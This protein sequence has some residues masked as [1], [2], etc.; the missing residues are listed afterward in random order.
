MKKQILS[1]Q[2]RRMQKLAGIIN[3]SE[4]KQDLEET[5]VELDD[6]EQ[7]VIDGL[8][9][10]MD[11]VLKGM[12]K[13]L[14]KVSKTA[15]EAILTTASIA[16]ALPA[17]I[18]LISRLGKSAGTLV[19]K[20]LGKKPSNDSDYQKWMAKL[21]D[22]ADQ[23]HHLYVI[24]IEAIVK[25]FVK[26]PKKA[27]KVANGIFHVIVAVLFIASGVTAVKALQTKNVSLATLESA[28][29]AVKG[30]EIQTYI[31]DLLS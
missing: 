23:L 26:D 19:N 14:E 17:I 3:E 25:K 12:E 6:Q 30:G 5:N 18:G 20:M 28:L 7:D 9:S 10:E 24:P 27:H 8:K 2:F 21:G 22:I 11:G 4:Y 13:E 31:S 16:L 29:S 1:E 15:N